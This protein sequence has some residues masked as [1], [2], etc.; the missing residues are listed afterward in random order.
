MAAA[1]VPSM[2]TEGER[3]GSRG[4]SARRAGGEG[5]ERGASVAQV[6]VSKPS[7]NLP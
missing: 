2:A 7:V 3:T 1:I 6:E 5:V 4:S